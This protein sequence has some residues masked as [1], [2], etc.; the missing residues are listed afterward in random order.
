MT[1]LIVASFCLQRQRLMHALRSDQNWETLLE[2]EKTQNYIK[3][4]TL[5][6]FCLRWPNSLISNYLFHLILEQYLTMYTYNSYIY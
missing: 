6:T 3:T 1:L 5:D 4:I 2:F